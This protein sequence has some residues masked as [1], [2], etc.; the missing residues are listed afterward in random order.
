MNNDGRITLSDLE[1]ISNQ[2]APLLPEDELKT[3]VEGFL[4]PRERYLKV[5]EKHPGP[6]YLLESA[7]QVKQQPAPAVEVHQPA[8][9]CGWCTSI[10]AM[11]K[12]K[13]KTYME[14]IPEQAAVSLPHPQHARWFGSRT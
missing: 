4:R 1:S 7:V 11:R 2:P 14:T 3:F 6:L 8:Q 13:S 12:G 5:V 9:A 10:G